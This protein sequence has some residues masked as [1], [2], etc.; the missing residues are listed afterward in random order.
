MPALFAIRP[1]QL[2]SSTGKVLVALVLEISLDMINQVMLNLV[3]MGESGDAYLVGQDHLLRSEPYREQGV[4]SIYDSFRNPARNRLDTR[5]IQQGLRGASGVVHTNNDLGEAVYTAFDNL[6]VGDHRWAMIVEVGDE[7]A[8]QLLNLLNWNLLVVGGV[9]LVLVLLLGYGLARKI[10]RPLQ[11]TTQLL[12]QVIADERF[13]QRLTVS[14]HDEVGMMAM[15]FNRLLEY[16]QESFLR[17][18]KSQKRIDHALYQLNE[19]QHMARI[20]SW[21]LDL[22]NNVLEW[23]D[24]IFSIF[25]IDKERFGASYEAFLEAVHP[26]DREQVDRVYRN[27][28]VQHS[29]YEYEHRLLMSDGRIKH[30][31]ESGFTRYDEHGEP[32]LSIGTVQDI[33]ERKKVDTV[34][35]K[36]LEEA[37]AAA[38]A[39][40][41]FLATMSHELRTP[42]TSI[43]GN[44]GFMLDAGDCGGSG[45]PRQDAQEILNSINSA[46]K[47]QLALVNDILDMSKLKSGKFTIDE[48]PYD[49]SVMLKELE[50]MFSVRAADAGIQFVLSQKHHETRLLKGDAQRISQVLINLIGNAVKFTEQGEVRLSVWL[51]NGQLFFQVKDTG[52]GMPK[53]VLDNLFQKFEQAEGSI[54][55]RFGG[56]GLGLY[57]SES[58]AKL[59]NGY[60]DVS[61]EEG[62]GSIF[63]LVLPY[64]PTDTRIV[65]A[66]EGQQQ[67]SVLDEKLSGHVLIAE[68]TPE[69]QML[70]SRILESV[71][72]D[73]TVVGDGKQAVEQVNSSHF[74]LVLMDMQMPVMD[75][76]EATRTLREQGHT[77]PIIALTANVM[78]KHREAFNAAGCDDFIGK[79][80]D[81]S[82]LR[83]VLKLHLRKS[84]SVEQSKLPEDVDDELMVIF[85]QSAA[86]Y[87]NA[88]KSALD[89]KD[90]KALRDTAHTVKGSA[91]SFGFNAISKKAE[92]LQFALDEEGLDSAPGLALDLVDE[93]GKIL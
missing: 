62:V 32:Y 87:N 58:L 75:G 68:D 19:A 92:A 57:I 91:A 54:S 15:Q 48:E 25:E 78:K 38:A 20:G 21:T 49:L 34:L 71:G 64:R 8:H 35:Q 11:Q 76:I 1:V 53:S 80:I 24:E 47:N 59:M 16:L 2:E 14:G 82:E 83:K 69:L 43:I 31:Q 5:A 45:C 40:D 55:R 9:V 46:G 12:Q 79:P 60:I 52:I 36:A 50:Q 39:K 41:D 90:W 63:Q 4:G 6:E 67:P 73:V 66:E 89:N 86:N 13:D 29:K 72:I 7:E 51:D 88:L 3:G 56:S 10:G 44:S 28:V 37:E 93:L 23:S 74:D 81:K 17:Q 18:E 26:E 77:L 70:E 84:E 85:K 65:Q 30:V 61:S 42:L 27:S 22:R 33:T